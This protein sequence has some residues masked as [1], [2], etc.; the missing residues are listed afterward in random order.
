MADDP[1]VD[2]TETEDETPTDTTGEGTDWKRESRKHERHAKQLRAE[3]EQ[4]KANPPPP[5]DAALAEARAAGRAEAEAELGGQLAAV[6]LEL[7]VLRT[8]GGRFADPADALRLLDPTDLL[9][10]TGQVDVALLERALDE[11][12]ASKPYLAAGTPTPRVPGGP[13]GP[14]GRTPDVA[15]DMNALIRRAAS[16]G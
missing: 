2:E 16:G 14:Q 12:L 6:R 5:D 10:A 9:D 13:R 11:L 8:A 15:A 7:A 3:L 1:T 4:L